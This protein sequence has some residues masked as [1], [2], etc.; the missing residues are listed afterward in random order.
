MVPRRNRGSRDIPDSLYKYFLYT[1]NL[2]FIKLNNHLLGIC[3]KGWIKTSEK[4]VLKT[5]CHKVLIEDRKT[6]NKETSKKNIH[7]VRN[8]V[9]ERVM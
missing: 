4:Q 6:F 2:S 7:E 8:G 5:T 9:L 1:T 3:P